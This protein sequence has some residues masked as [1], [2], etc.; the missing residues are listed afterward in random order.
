MPWL[1]KTIWER[2]KIHL[3]P[4]QNYPKRSFNY[5]IIIQTV[6]L[7]KWKCIMTK[8]SLLLIFS[9]FVDL[10]KDL[11]I[12][13]LTRNSGS[14]PKKDVYAGFLLVSPHNGRTICRRWRWIGHILWRPDSNIAKRAL[15]W[16]PQGQRKRGRPRNTWRR[17]VESDASKLGKSWSQIERDSQDRVLWRSVVDG[18][19]SLVG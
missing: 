1:A 5:Q 19:C 15:R 7:F 3:K 4:F 11:L 17:E 12:I 13:S 18:L 6:R 16:N 10:N 14:A 8:M 9:E 2:L